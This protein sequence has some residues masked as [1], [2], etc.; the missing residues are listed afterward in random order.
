MA[1]PKKME[2]MTMLRVFITTR[3]AIRL[4]AIKKGM[5]IPEYLDFLVKNSKE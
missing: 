4:R 2:G 3:M 5:T 1:K